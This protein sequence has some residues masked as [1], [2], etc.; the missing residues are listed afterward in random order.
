MN[1]WEKE[2]SNKLYTIFHRFHRPFQVRI[3]AGVPIVF[4]FFLMELR[5]EHLDRAGDRA[6]AHG[7]GRRDGAGG[8]GRGGGDG[9]LAVGAD[10][11]VAARE[12]HDGG[13]RP[14]ACPAR[15]GRRRRR[16]GDLH[17]S[18]RVH[19]AR[20]DVVRRR[21][22]VVLLF[23][24]LAPRLSRGRRLLQLRVERRGRG[25]V[26]ERLRLPR[27]R[28]RP[29]PRHPVLQ[30]GATPHGLRGL[31]LLLP[32]PLRRRRL[33]RDEQ[34]AVLP[35]PSVSQSAPEPLRLQATWSPSATEAGV[36]RW[37]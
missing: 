29:Q 25:L 6:A 33:G 32:N 13:R 28:L 3:L 26:R 9:G 31:R 30:V 21:A 4:S 24:G 12:Q 2:R 20:P 16:R 7:A 5:E 17:H 18:V 1:K 8:E 15:P 14:P 22:R 23:L 10:A 37:R 35:P 19:E 27:R 36:C 34:R 11:E